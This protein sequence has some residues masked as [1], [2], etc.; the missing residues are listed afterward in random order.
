MI[1]SYP[2]VYALG[3]PAIKDLFD[4]PVVVQE[5]VDGSQFSWSVQDG[6]LW[7]RSRGKQLHLPVTDKLFAGACDTATQLHRGGKLVEGWQYRGEAISKPKHNTQEYDRT[8]KGN[9][10]LFDV[11]QR[12]EDRVADPADLAAIAA[13]LGLECVPL[14]YHGEVEDLE[15]LKAFLD[16]ESI[17]GGCKVEG[18]V[19]KNY[20]RWG[21]DGKQLM[22]KLV[23]EEFR[24]KHAHEWKRNNPGRADIVEGL[25]E[26]YRTEARWRKAIQHAAE[27]GDLENSPRDIGHLLKAIK[28]DVFEECGEEIAAALFKEFWPQIQ[29]G[30]T[31]GF[32][33]WYKEQLAQQQFKGD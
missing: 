25:K 9:V 28:V 2:K 19:V 12:V 3:H 6:E 15:T 4:G 30:I 21:R 18:V 17:L 27:N 33:E 11:D 32:P 10:I 5:K 14:L 23:S 13:E 22:G 26:A 8:P 20:Q 24:E 7:C 29:R 1:N 16:R 31:A